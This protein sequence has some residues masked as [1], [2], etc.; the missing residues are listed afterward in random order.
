MFLI[1]KCQFIISSLTSSETYISFSFFCGEPLSKLFD[2]I[3]QFEEV[4][5][6]KG[7]VP[8]C[9]HQSIINLLDSNI[10]NPANL[11]GEE[12]DSTFCFGPDGG[13]REIIRVS[14]ICCVIA[15]LFYDYQ[16]ASKFLD[17]CK[18]YKEYFGN[19]LLKIIFH[20]YDGL[21]ASE[22]SRDAQDKEKYEDM[23][24]ESILNLKRYAQNAPINYLNKC[25]LLEAELAVTCNKRPEAISHY[26]KAISLSKLHGFANEEAMACERLAIFHLELG[27]QQDATLLLVQSFNKYKDW[28]AV[29]KMLHLIKTYKFLYDALKASSNELVKFGET[30]RVDDDVADAVSLLTNLTSTS[31]STWEGQK[32]V[33]LSISNSE[34][35]T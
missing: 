4:L 3:C 26:E 33:R 32:Q 13:K 34:P 18:M 19:I 21:V 10:K 11:S 20:F 1:L 29:S 2:E 8:S 7:K 35:R 5:P 27:S 22:M 15:Y 23:M 25:H 24:K 9:L 12:F 30:L 31:L 16:G 14:T 28:G 17:I 6:H